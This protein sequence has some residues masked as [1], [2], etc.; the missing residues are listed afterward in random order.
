MFVAY[1][2]LD[3]E[4]EIF[5]YIRSKTDQLVCQN[6][7]EKRNRFTSVNMHLAETP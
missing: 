7:Y 3:N 6:L 1:D 4:G 2:L 5:K